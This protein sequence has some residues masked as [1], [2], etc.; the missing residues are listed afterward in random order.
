M[1]GGSFNML[2]SNG[3][4]VEITAFELAN[5]SFDME[6][7]E[8]LF[9]TTGGTVVTLPEL[10]TLTD[11]MFGLKLPDEAIPLVSVMQLAKVIEALEDANR[12]EAFAIW[13]NNTGWGNIPTWSMGNVGDEF[14]KSY[15]GSYE[16][17]ADSVADEIEENVPERM[18]PYVEAEEYGKWVATDSYLVEEG[19]TGTLHFFNNI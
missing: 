14:H 3:N 5:P 12:E 17:Y 6:E 10:V 11:N 1:S 9:T 2:D 8:L 4:D 7:V 16:S 15:A 13:I 18:R 19:K